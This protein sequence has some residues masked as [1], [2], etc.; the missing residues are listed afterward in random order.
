VGGVH[1]RRDPVEVERHQQRR[2][3]HE[4]RQPRGQQ[5]QPLAATARD[6]ALNLHDL[7]GAVLGTDRQRRAC[8]FRRRGLCRARRGRKT[9]ARRLRWRRLGAARLGGRCARTHVDHKLQLAAA[10][11]GIDPAMTQKTDGVEIGIGRQPVFLGDAAGHA[12][13]TAR[14]ALRADGGKFLFR[15]RRA[16][17]GL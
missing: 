15:G 14:Q 11:E 16:A 12:Q 7:G 8:G 17:V 10:G 2:Q 1:R 4:E 13:L 5:D 3:Q 6:V 9:V